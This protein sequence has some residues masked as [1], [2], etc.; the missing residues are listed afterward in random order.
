ME[1]RGLPG[2]W[3]VVSLAVVPGRF[4]VCR[5]DADAALPAWAVAGDFFA[6]ARTAEEVS[7]VCREEAVPEGVRRAAGW[8]CLKV[9]GPLAFDETGILAA[10]AGPLAQA[11]IALF[12]LSTFDTDY[13]LVPQG[14]LPEALDALARHGHVVRPAPET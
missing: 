8:A 11:G 3:R 12:A 13:L 6:V 14:A 1:D 4:A 5:L 7:V 10:L 2:K 9:D